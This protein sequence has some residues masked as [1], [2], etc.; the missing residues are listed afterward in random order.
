ASRARANSIREAR[1]IWSAAVE[2]EGTPVR[3]YLT[4]RGITPALLP[5]LPASIRYQPDARYMHPAKDRPREWNLLHSGPAMV[6][7]VTDAR[8]YVTAVH[9]TWIDLDQPSGKLVLADPQQP[10]RKLPSKKV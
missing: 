4:R 1:S 9:R 7:A 6:A 3:D 10:D 8:G 2:A 5:E